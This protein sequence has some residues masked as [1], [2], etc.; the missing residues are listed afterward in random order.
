MI[1][2]QTKCN[3]FFF[4]F[5]KM[6][7]MIARMVNMDKLDKVLWIWKP[8]IVWCAAVSVI[9]NDIAK[10][11]P[12][13]QVKTTRES[14]P[15]SDFFAKISIY[16]NILITEN[17]FHDWKIFIFENIFDIWEL[18][19]GWLLRSPARWTSLNIPLTG[20]TSK[21]IR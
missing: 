8:T 20:D 19:A 13:N 16:Q 1:E 21:D 10:T 6:V 2:P 14:P 5:F 12:A 4:L 17:K 3:T 11:I 9:R 7:N 18:F 15:S